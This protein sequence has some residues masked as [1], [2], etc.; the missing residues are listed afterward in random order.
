M[1]LKNHVGTTYAV[2]YKHSGVCWCHEG[3]AEVS[4]SVLVEFGLERVAEVD[5]ESISCCE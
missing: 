5:V 2:M 3:I 4:S 1:I